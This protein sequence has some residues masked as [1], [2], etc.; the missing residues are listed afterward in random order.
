MED[1]EMKSEMIP[2]IVILTGRIIELL[3]LM[4]NTEMMILE[5][6]NNNEYTNIILSQFE[7]LPYSIIKL[8]LERNER[9]NNVGR[10]INML[11]ILKNVKSGEQDINEAYNKYSEQLNEE[12]I[13]PKFGG[14]NNFEKEI[15][16]K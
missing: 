14:K 11:N 12:Y 2:D 3:K 16:N 13:Y 5:K 8:L 4:D 6:G 7:D 15:K 9:E 1:K 10:L